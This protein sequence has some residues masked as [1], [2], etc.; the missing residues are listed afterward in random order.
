MGKLVFLGGTC[1]N[2]V[3]RPDFIARLVA[4]G[5][6]AAT[7]FDPVVDD[8]NEAAQKK[9]DEVKVSADYMLFL[10][11]DPQQADNRTS[12]YSLCEAFL[13]LINAPART[14]VVFDSTGM[15]GHLVKSMAKTYKD[16]K[17]QFPSAPIFGTLAEAEAW[18]VRELAPAA[19]AP[20]ANAE[21]P[22]T[23]TATS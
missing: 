13:G 6:P 14:V 2:N 20:E 16:M 11:G 12:F 1:G 3:W 17:K 8:W 18:L 15:P 23:E 21:V 5:V 4:L 19:P 10:L 9:E 7:L 22:A